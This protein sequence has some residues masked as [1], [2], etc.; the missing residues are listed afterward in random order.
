MGMQKA[1]TFEYIKEIKTILIGYIFNINYIP[2][3]FIKSY[4]VYLKFL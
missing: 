4:S 1:K 3:E 2:F